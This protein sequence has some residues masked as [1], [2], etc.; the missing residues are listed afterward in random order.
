MVL[1]FLLGFFGTGFLCWT[2]IQIKKI[3]N[4]II[5]K[6][7]VIKDLLSFINSSSKSLRVFLTSD[8][9][10]LSILL[11][12]QAM[13]SPFLLTQ[14]LPPQC[15]LI[16][17]DLILASSKSIVLSLIIQLHVL[18]K[19]WI[20]SSRILLVI[21]WNSDIFSFDLKPMV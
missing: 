8:I 18:A 9:I 10:W 5:T 13:V 2:E 15:W 1:F 16:L 6:I 4:N 3:T 19:I 14:W 7:P 11:A 17:R 21:C 20:L 12:P